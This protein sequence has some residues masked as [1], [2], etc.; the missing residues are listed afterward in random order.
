MLKNTIYQMSGVLALAMVVA[1]CPGRPTEESSRLD[2]NHFL[3]VFQNVSSADSA[4]DLPDGTTYHFS[5]GVSLNELGMK[6]FFNRAQSQCKGVIQGFNVKTVALTILAAEEISAL[7]DIFDEQALV[8]L[9]T[10]LPGGGHIGSTIAVSTYENPAGG[11]LES[12]PLDGLGPASLKLTESSANSALLF[13]LYNTD[14]RLNLNMVLEGK[15]KKAIRFKADILVDATIDPVCGVPLNVAPWSLE[16]TATPVFGNGKP[17]PADTQVSLVSATISGTALGT[18]G[19]P[20]QSASISVWLDLTT[21]KPLSV[22]QDQTIIATLEFPSSFAGN[23]VV[24]ASCAPVAFA[25]L[26]TGFESPTITALLV[27]NFSVCSVYCNGDASPA[28]CTQNC[29]N[30]PNFVGTAYFDGPAVKSIN[31]QLRSSRASIVQSDTTFV[32][33]YPQH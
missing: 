29:L 26:A 19:C 5:K 9:S 6:D 12:V 15:Y 14:P 28:R 11:P 25:D 1:G 30:G 7:K 4:N 17:L 16:L 31:D 3:I 2:G 21:H 27:P 22:R 13:Q 18:T 8:S 10:N 23:Q 20:A 24:P 32:F 33:Y